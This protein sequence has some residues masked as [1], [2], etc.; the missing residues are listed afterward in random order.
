MKKFRLTVEDTA[1]QAGR[2]FVAEADIDYST[3]PALDPEWIQFCW[4][5]GYDLNKTRVECIRVEENRNGQWEIIFDPW[6][7]IF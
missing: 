6:Y 7:G 1:N 4:L 5:H 3:C 2:G